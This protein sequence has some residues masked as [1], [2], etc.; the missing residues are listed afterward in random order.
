MKCWVEWMSVAHRRLAYIM[1]SS[2]KSLT[3][4]GQLK[5]HRRLSAVQGKPLCPYREENGLM[6]SW[7]LRSFRFSRGRLP[8]IV[9]LLATFNRDHSSR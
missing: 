5:L 6:L 9:V 3:S 4:Q 1:R 2:G 7:A 8:V